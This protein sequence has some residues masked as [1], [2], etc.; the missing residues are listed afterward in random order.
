MT[1]QYLYP[2][3]EAGKYLF[4]KN[5]EGAIV[6]LNLIRLKE[7][8]DYAAYPHLQPASKISG[9]EAFEKYIEAAKPFLEASCGEILFIGKG[10]RFLIGPD[11]EHWD[12]CMLVRQNSVRDFFEF[13]QNEAY[14]RIAGHRMA[15]IEDARLLPLE[16][17][18][19]YAIL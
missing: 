7:Y 12:I 9:R 17:L 2:D 15:A 10:D 11:Q 13:E 6:N 8:A 5:I 1:T 19:M 3:Y 16:E 18:A 4:S 14:L